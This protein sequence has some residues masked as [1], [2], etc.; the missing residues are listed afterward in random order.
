MPVVR[1]LFAQQT[2]AIETKED[3][4]QQAAPTYVFHYTPYSTETT[5]PI[6]VEMSYFGVIRRRHCTLHS[7]MQITIDSQSVITRLKTDSIE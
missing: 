3:L 7:T 5:A 1:C 4:W 6:L 2:R